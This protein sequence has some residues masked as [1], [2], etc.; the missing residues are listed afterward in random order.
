MKHEIQAIIQKIHED[1]EHHGKE[2]YYQIKEEIDETLQNELQFHSDEL[3]KRREMLLKNNDHEY[4]KMLERLASR[5]NRE[6]LSYQHQLIDEI[7]DQAVE[8]L[9]N[10]S[11]SA[12]NQLFLDSVRGLTGE[13]IIH[14][15][16]LSVSKFDLNSMQEAMN[17]NEGL[18][19][20]LSQKQVQ[21]KS[22]FVLHDNRVEYNC[23]F[24]DVIESMKSEQS[25]GILKEVFDS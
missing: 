13:Y 17:Q 11:A 19:L 25:A 18:S 15:G 5:M 14:L 22:G 12:F 4:S 16:T 21:N 7:F 20:T 6:Y 24:E 2:R 8:K 1:G 9:R 23:L 3:V 10:T